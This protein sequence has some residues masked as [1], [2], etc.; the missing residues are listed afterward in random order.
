MPDQSSESI[1]C[2]SVNATL[3]GYPWREQLG[4]ID[5]NQKI[6]TTTS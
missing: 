3:H 6:A 2:E 1:S 4:G 5:A